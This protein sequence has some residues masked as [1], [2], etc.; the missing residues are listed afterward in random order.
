[1]TKV[2]ACIIARTVSK[3]LPLKVLRDLEPGISMLDFLIKRIKTVKSIDEIYLCTSDELVDDILEDV[4]L[5]NNIKL[6]RGSADGVIERI[7]GVS[8]I[9]NADILLRITGDNPLASIEF[10]DEQIN[11]LKTNHLDY[12]RVIDVPIG[13][14]IEVMTS[15]ALKKCYNNM[16]PSVSEYLMLFIFEPQN[17]KCGI[18]KAFEKDYS[19]YSVTVDTP[20]DLKRT[21]GILKLINKEPEN[22]LLENIIETYNENLDKLPAMAIKQSGAVK[23][24]FE[25]IITFEEFTL[26]MKRRK[27]QSLLLKIYE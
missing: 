6:Y 9:E 8:E 26:D 3:R 24:P 15:E 22:I 19:Y 21:K 16:D 18:I 1:M 13:A 27:D 17:Y 4:A 20:D 11:M 25:K 2:V 14:T 5:K 10:I 7:I 23:Y 12:V